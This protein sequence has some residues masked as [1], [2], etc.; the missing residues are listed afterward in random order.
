MSSLRAQQ[1]AKKYRSKKVVHDVSVTLNTGEVV[2]LLGPNG[3][4]KTTIFYMLAGLVRPGNGHIYIDNKKITRLS[5]SKRA[6]MGI[7]YLPQ[8]SSIFRKL[9]V[10][11]NILAILQLRKDLDKKQQKQQL[12]KLLKEFHIEH[13]RKSIGYSLSGGERKRVEIA[14]SIASNPKFILFDEPFSGIDPIS[15]I[16]IKHIIGHLRDSGVGI[17]ITDHNVR[18]ALDICERAYIVDQGKILCEGAPKEI[19]QNETVK[20]VYLGDNFNL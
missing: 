7:G 13:I 12:S 10:E 5:L 15:I 1:L 11:D 19:L 20:K 9:S 18:E 3:A 16:D 17:L 6:Q 8:D 2:G 14:R 4:G